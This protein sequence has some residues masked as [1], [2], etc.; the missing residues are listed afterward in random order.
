MNDHCLAGEHPNLLNHQT[1][2]H[3]GDKN[4]LTKSKEIG[5]QL[6]SHFAMDGIQTHHRHETWLPFLSCKLSVLCMTQLGGYAETSY[7]AHHLPFCFISL[8]LG[9]WWQISFPLCMQRRWRTWVSKADSTIWLIL[10]LSND[11][12]QPGNDDTTNISK[13]RLFTCQLN[14]KN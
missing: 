3:A 8:N 5:L 7:R 10:Q 12:E 1:P 2:P 13:I 11:A 6:Q 14:D 4:Y 9:S